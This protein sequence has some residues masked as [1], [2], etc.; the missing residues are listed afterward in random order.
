M[1]ALLRTRF[2]HWMQRRFPNIECHWDLHLQR[3]SN[4]KAEDLWEAFKAGVQC[5]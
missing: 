3:Y 5:A 4:T 2:Q 1:T